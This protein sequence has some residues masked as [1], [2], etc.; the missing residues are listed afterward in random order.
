LLQRPTAKELLR[1]KF[2][3]KAKKLSYLIELIDKFKRWTAEHRDEEDEDEDE[4][5]L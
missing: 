2:I 1:N 5:N 3:L 4:D